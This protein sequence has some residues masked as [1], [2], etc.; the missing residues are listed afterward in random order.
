MKRLFVTLAFL[1]FVVKSFAQDLCGTPAITNIENVKKLNSPRNRTSKSFYILKVYFHVIRS[2]SGAGGVSTSDVTSAY[3]RLNSDFNSHGIY[4]SWDGI[5]DPID[6]DTYYNNIPTTNIF[7]E[8]NHTN[9]IDIYLYPADPNYSTPIIGL[10]NGVGMSSEFY[11]VGRVSGI[12]ACTTSTISHEMGH[13]LNLWHTHHGTY[14]EGGNDNPCP[15]LVNGNNSSTCGDY[16]E[17][18]P[19]D[20][21]LSTL[22]VYNCVYIGYG[23]D[24][25]DQAYNP[26]V[27]LI[28]SYAPK[29][30]RTRFSAKQGERMR[31]SIATLSYLIQTQCQL[32]ITG[33]S[34]VCSTESYSIQNFP[35]GSTVVWSTSNSNLTIVS[36]QGTGTATFQKNANG[37][38]VVTAQVSFGSSTLDL[39]KDVWA[40]VPSAPT[41]LGWPNTNMF[42]ANSQYQLYAS[43]NSQAQVL[44]YQWDVVR[45]ATITSG[46]NTNSPIFTMNPNGTVRIGVRARNAC[47][48]GPY[49][50]LNGGIT[51]DNGQTPINSPGNN[52]VNIPLP[53]DGEYEITLWNNNRLIRTVKTTQSSYDVD[54][55]N[56]PP[57]LYIIKVAKDGKRIYQLKIFSR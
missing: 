13:V 1:A 2:T 50:Y 39:T 22:N 48:W 5:I 26:D 31:E 37:A 30:C 45:G 56:L 27:D 25:N 41:I 12:P 28:M 51:N 49:T 21:R 33:C 24:A 55:N 3:S 36:G 52:I 43:V 32:S 40:G 35:Y 23:T 14:D 11:I 54:L 42:L 53:E 10:A 18:T 16:I 17:D 57:D 44:E 15:E 20:P 6:N 19:A 8:N 4:F 7:Y 47:G 29:S 34:N 46:G 38:C 9:G